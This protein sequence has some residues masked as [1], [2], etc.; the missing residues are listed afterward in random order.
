MPE[1][2]PSL[3]ITVTL[4]GNAYK[5]ALTL[6]PLLTVEVSNQP[7][8]PVNVLKWATVESDVVDQSTSLVTSCVNVSPV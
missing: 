4:A 1:V 2:K 3:V 7:F 6:I 8:S 5:V